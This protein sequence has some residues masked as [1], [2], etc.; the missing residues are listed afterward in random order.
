[1][2]LAPLAL[3]VLISLPSGL[4]AQTWA[5]VAV[6]TCTR[7]DSLLGAPSGAAGRVQGIYDAKR[8]TIYLLAGSPKPAQTTELSGNLA[9]HHGESVDSPAL[10]FNLLL[11]G[12][13]AVKAFSAGV[14]TALTLSLGDTT[15]IM[16]GVLERRRFESSIK[17]SSVPI[18]LWLAPHSFLALIQ[19]EK[20]E[21]HVGDFAYAMTAA[22][23]RDFTA[24][25]RVAVCGTSVT[26]QVKHAAVRH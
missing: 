26:T 8:D 13:D 22:Q 25:Y 24:L 21:M 11:R 3:G 10:Q 9:L 1:V 14:S 7:A 17:A 19:A 5:P 12:P 18:S 15:L 4:A 20:A 23:R 16:F 2:R 6:A